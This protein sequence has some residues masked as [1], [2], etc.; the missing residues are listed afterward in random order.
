MNV[1]KIVLSLAAALL[2]FGCGQD[3]QSRDDVPPQTPSIVPRSDDSAYPQAG[4]RAEPTLT[5]RNYWTR[6][7]WYRNP[8]SDIASYRV[9]RWSEQV[10]ASEAPIVADLSLG[11]DLLDS[12]ILS[13]ID[14]GDD[15]F[16]GTANLLAPNDQ[17]LT[18]GYWWQVQAIDTA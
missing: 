10:S 11:V 14:R 12:Y 5:D 8:E 4:V 13:W 15:Q 7:E 1:L 18:R 9:R 16:G 2:V 6:I 17:G 3:T